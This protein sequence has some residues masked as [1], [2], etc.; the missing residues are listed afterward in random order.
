[1]SSR[2]AADPLDGVSIFVHLGSQ[3]DCETKTF[4]LQTLLL[5]ALEDGYAPIDSARDRG[6]VIRHMKQTGR[7]LDELKCMLI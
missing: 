1:V 6:A 4:L 7:M 2:L 5:H 3:P